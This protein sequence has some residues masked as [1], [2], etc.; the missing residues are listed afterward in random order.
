MKKSFRLCKISFTLLLC[1]TLVMTSFDMTAYASE[2]VERVEGAMGVTGGEAQEGMGNTEDAGSESPGEE[3]EPESKSETEQESEPGAEPETEQESEPETELETEPVSEPATETEQPQET[4]EETGVNGTVIYLSGFAPVPEEYQELLLEQKGTLSEAVAKMPASLT[5]YLKRPEGETG[6]NPEEQERIEV[7]VSW[8]CS[9]DYENTELDSYTFLPVVNAAGYAFA[10]EIQER[11]VIL[12]RIRMQETVP[13]TAVYV[14]EQTALQEAVNNGAEYVALETDIALSAALTIPSDA[15]LI[16]DGQG[17]SLLRGYGGDGQYDG[18]LLFLAGEPGAQEGQCAD[19]TLKNCRVNGQSDNGRSGAPAVITYGRLKMDSGAVVENN[20][21]YGTYEGEVIPDYGGGIQVFRELEIAEGAL[22]TGNFADELGGGVYLADGAVLY[23]LAD[24]V[25]GNLVGESDG[26]GSDIYACNGSTIYFAGSIVMDRENFY[27]CPNAVLINLDQ[28]LMKLSDSDADIEI[29]LSISEGSGYSMDE[30]KAQLEQLGER[31]GK[32]IRILTARQAIDTTDLTEWYVYDHYDTNLNCWDPVDQQPANGKPDAWETAYANSKHRKYYSYSENRVYTPVNPVYTIS[33]WL[34]STEYVGH[35]RLSAF[36]EHIYTRTHKGQ[37]EMTFVGYGET[38]NVDFLYYDPQSNGEKVVNFD[39]DSSQVRTHTLA[40]N[41]FL[42]NTG[43]NGNNL[44]GYLV[45]YTYAADAVATRVSIREL[46]NI[47]ADNFHNGALSVAS[48]PE[49]AGAVIPAGAWDTQMSIEIIAKPGSI[50]VRQKPLAADGDVSKTTPLLTYQITN[51]TGYSG[52]G[53]LVAY[54]SHSC[55]MASSF[56]YSNLRMYFTNP[57]LEKDTLLNPF[58]DADFTQNTPEKETRKY[59][60]NLV[61]DAQHEGVPLDYNESSSFAHYQAYLELMQREGVGLITDKHTPFEAY[62]GPSGAENSNLQ[63]VTGSSGKPTVQELM[64]Q[65]QSYLEKNT[66]TAWNPDAFDPVLTPANS[67]V[68]AG[69]IWLADSTGAQIR[70]VIEEDMLDGGYQITIRDDQISSNNT[71]EAV[72]Y[73]IQKPGSVEFETLNV[74]GGSFEITENASDWPAGSYIVRQEIGDSSVYGHAGF[75]VERPSYRLY[76]DANGGSGAPVDNT[77]YKRGNTATLQFVPKPTKQGMQFWG[78]SRQK[79]AITPEFTANNNNKVTFGKSSI[80]LYA[81][82]IEEGFNVDGDVKE[83]GVPVEGATVKLIR[84]N[85]VYGPPCQTDVTGHFSFTSIAPGIYN[86]V[87][88]KGERIVTRFFEVVDQDVALGTI[89][90]PIGIIN[91]RL[92]VTPDTPDIV[93]DG[94]DTLY[95]ANPRASEPEKGYTDA[96]A[97]IVAGGGKAEFILTCTQKADET[98]TEE[99]KKAAEAIRQAAGVDGRTVG[100]LIDFS[101]DKVITP[102]VGAPFSWQQTETVSNIGL[103]I[104]LPAQLQGKNDYTIYRYHNGVEELTGTPNERGESF[105]GI[106]ETEMTADFEAGKFSLYAIAYRP[107]TAADAEIHGS[108]SHS[109]RQEPQPEQLT[110]TEEIQ[111]VV[112]Q[113][114]PQ[115][116]SQEVS[117]TGEPRTG[118]SRIPV[119]P[120]A[121]GAVTVFMIKIMLWMYELEFGI[122]QEQKDAMIKE[123]TDWARGTNRFRIYLAVGAMTAVLVWYHLSI[124]LKNNDKQMVK[125][126]ID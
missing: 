31:L 57:K 26:F 114:V 19:L 46:R 126:E 85:T 22:V 71:G 111:P 44:N 93:V 23:L 76:Y 18:V 113:E 84:A 107:E 101:L 58:Q 55:S 116:V 17:H 42:V 43:V 50:T 6:E 86:V 118:D 115:E 122:T 13:D 54:Q 59:F 29:F 108:N 45:Y 94:L 73:F 121:A 80:T 10:E 20:Y 92:Q 119:M 3:S 7:P 104:F 49:V 79:N 77:L 83:D 25:Q 30:V 60:L 75:E 123:L 5:A 47:N 9:Q 14:S 36:K 37:P 74:N 35:T 28:A 2:T 87:I 16:L 65:L 40:G 112:P 117:R 67:N 4:G 124:R 72:K 110:A 97:Q 33:K 64:E 63:E 100:L 96:D 62:L 95:L 91:S 81:V 120:V 109:A 99:E 98:M 1:L 34:D 11:P 38:P 90:M 102:L 32:N 53:P 89:T 24:A 15:S 70:D 51:P 21:N 61:G 48:L 27:L 78:W 125:K 69:N 52:F 88:E 8:Q 103:H 12:V 41:G 82:W 56:T 68:S 105:L 106:H 66:T 39:V